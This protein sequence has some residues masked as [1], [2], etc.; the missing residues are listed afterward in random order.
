M[1][2]PLGRFLFRQKPT[3]TNEV[4][5]YDETKKGGIGMRFSPYRTALLLLVITAIF[6]GCSKQSSSQSHTY[7]FPTAQLKT[8]E[9]RNTE[10]KKFVAFVRKNIK[11]GMTK[12]EVVA[13]MGYGELYPQVENV[14]VMKYTLDYGDNTSQ[15]SDVDY[16]AF[17]NKQMGAA[18]F[19]SF[20]SI[21]NKVIKYE[22]YDVNPKNDSKREKVATMKMITD[23]GI[24]YRLSF[25]SW[26]PRP[27]K[28]N[29]PKENAYGNQASLVDHQYAWSLNSTDVPDKVLIRTN[30]G[31]KTWT[32]LGF[33]SQLTPN[34]TITN[35]ANGVQFLNHNRGW[36]L[37][38]YQVNNKNVNMIY[39]TDDGGQSWKPQELPSIP[40]KLGNNDFSTLRNFESRDIIFFNQKVGIALIFADDGADSKWEWIYATQDGGNTWSKPLPV[41]GLKGDKKGSILG[42]EW[43]FS[44]PDT[45]VFKLK[46][47][48]YIYDAANTQ[49]VKF[50]KE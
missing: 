39:M 27:T 21:T 15:G 35:G 45:R 44:K 14:A 40:V 17:L 2:R 29:Y 23:K 47:A 6:T 46:N 28:L 31:G 24:A 1:K 42:I 50:T 16:N 18:L 41:E 32:K 49:W 48:K 33:T 12:D 5:A 22:L 8:T 10:I 20:D 11:S 4:D 13:H 34:Y 26:Y 30:D 7:T 25:D 9:V 37:G 38:R 43:D 36:L 19:L 3:D